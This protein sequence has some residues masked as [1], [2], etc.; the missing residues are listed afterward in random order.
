VSAVVDRN[1]QPRLSAVCRCSM[2][3]RPEGLQRAL[4]CRAAGGNPAGRQRGE[5]EHPDR[6]E[7][8]GG[9]HL[10]DADQLSAQRPGRDE[11][12]D[13]PEQ[14]AG[15]RQTRDLPNHQREH[16]AGSGAERQPQPEL[17]ASQRH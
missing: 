13:K 10:F 5:H 1:L 11:G 8:A 16:L 15:D 17:V 4:P 14:E 7:V 9:V 12:T 3:L 2:S 6:G